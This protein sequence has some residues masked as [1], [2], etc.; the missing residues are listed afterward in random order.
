V[1]GPQTSAKAFQAFVQD[2]WGHQDPSGKGPSDAQIADMARES[3][4]PAKAVDAIKAGKSALNV[5]DMSDTN[6]EYLY[7]INPVDTGT[8]TVYDLIKADTVDIY[9]NNWLSKLLSRS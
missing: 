6:F 1:A 9:D 2:L 5:Q 4:I 8:P 3:G 7:E